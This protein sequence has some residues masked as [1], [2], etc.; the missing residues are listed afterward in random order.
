M[1]P[2]ARWV[3]PDREM[4]FLGEWQT[5][6]EQADEFESSSAASRLDTPPTISKHRLS[7]IDSPHCRNEEVEEE[8]TKR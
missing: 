2:V 4:A 3:A 7:V 5:G 1:T 6:S 8:A